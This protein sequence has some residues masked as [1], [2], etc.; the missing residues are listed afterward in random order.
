MAKAS[1]RHASSS[2]CSISLSHSH[3]S[4]SGT[5]LNTTGGSKTNNPYLLISLTHAGP[6]WTIIDPSFDPS[7]IILTTLVQPELRC[8]QA[9]IDNSTLALQL[10]YSINA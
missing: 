2:I 5:L 10:A 8:G 3:S 7:L 6:S 9:L 1:R 4:D